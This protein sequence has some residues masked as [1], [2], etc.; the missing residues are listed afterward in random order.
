MKNVIVPFAESAVINAGVPQGSL[1]VFV[2]LAKTESPSWHWNCIFAPALPCVAHVSVNESLGSMRVFE[3]ANSLADGLAR[4]G[5]PCTSNV[6][7]LE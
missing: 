2:E 7:T 5:V 1:V 4:S 3:L 6:A